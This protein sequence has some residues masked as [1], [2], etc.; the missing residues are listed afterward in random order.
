MMVYNFYIY[1]LYFRGEDKAILSSTQLARIKSM[2]YKCTIYAIALYILAIAQVTFFNKINLFGAPPDLLLAAIATLCMKE[3]HK[4]C[5]ICGIV[6]GFFYCALGGAQSPLYMIFSFLCAYIFF[7]MAERS[8]KQT[9]RSYF[10]LCALIFA[11]KAVF[12]IVETS[13]FSSSFVLIRIFVS[14][15]LPE[16][17]SSM[18][19]CLLSYFLFGL[20]AALINKKSQKGQS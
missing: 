12:N 2:G 9:I 13:I 6:S 18:A 10:T 15:V 14:A 1:L 19:F 17:I 20:I 3:E 8:K 11:V 4:I 16:Y 5:S 7:F